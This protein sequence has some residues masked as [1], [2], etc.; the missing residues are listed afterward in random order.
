MLKKAPLLCLFDETINIRAN[1]PK[2]KSGIGEEKE[3]NN[4]NIIFYSNSN[5]YY[6]SQKPINLIP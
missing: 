5:E 4:N 2:S 3:M 6:V 1:Q